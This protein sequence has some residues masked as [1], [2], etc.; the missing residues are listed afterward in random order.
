MARDT[1]IPSP[2]IAL[3]PYQRDA[4]D[5]LYAYW[6]REKG[7][8]LIVAPTGSGKSILIATFVR[9]AREN[10]PGTRFL[11]AT[12]VKE[13]IAQNFSA[14]LRAW[15]TAPAGIYSAGL[16]QRSI[17]Q[18]IIFCGIQ[19][20]HARAEIFGHV[21]LLLVDEAHLIPRNSDTMYG[22]FIAALRKINPAMKVVGFTATPYRL[23]SGRLDKGDTRIFDGIAFDIGIARLVDEGHLAPLVSKATETALDVSGVKKRGGEYIEAELQKAVDKE[24]VTEKAVAEIVRYGETRK[25]WLL[26]CAGVDHARH[27]A[28]ALVRLGINAAFVHGGMADR[29]RDRALSAFKAG[30]LRAVANANLLTTGFDHPTLDLIALL[31]PTLSTGLYVQMLGRGMRPAPGKENCIAEGQRVLTNT[32][33][34]PIERVTTAMKVWD[35]VE[36]VSH[37]GIILQGEQEVITY[38]GLTATPDHKVWTTKGWKALGKCAVERTPVRITGIEGK[39]VR[40][41]VGCDWHDNQKDAQGALAFGSR[42]FDLRRALFEGIY[43]LKEKHCRLPK[44]RQSEAGS[45]VACYAGHSS[46]AALHKSEGQK[47]PG[48]WGAWDRISLFFSNGNGGLDSGEFGTSPQYGIGSSEQRWSLRGWK[49]SLRN[50]KGSKEKHASRRKKAKVYDII[51]SGP[52]HR[53]T[54]EGL[55]V[56]N[57]VILDFARN[58]ARHGPVDMVTIKE[59]GEGGGVAPVKI[60]LDCN[61]ILHTAIRECPD[62]GYVFPFKTADDKIEASASK[63]AVMARDLIPTWTRCARWIFARHEKL[64]GLPTVRVEYQCGLQFHR[65]WLCPQHDGFARRKFE[66]WWLT[67]EGREPFPAT[68]EDVLSRQGELTCPSEIMVRKAG[69]Y[70]EIASRRFQRQEEAA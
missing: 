47:I 61:S 68:V 25:S 63:A 20:V 37:D 31:R 60:C 4:L 43:Q 67:H 70:F 1:A 12:H 62:C 36:F 11:I 48:L 53:F 58:I 18:P 5:G 66:R 8:P 28:E 51:N 19:S 29:E 49:S 56:S 35:G 22:R 21:D 59:P 30:Q 57:C 34:V 15:P 3:R 9:E 27:V 38:A 2:M 64:G 69:K 17:G 39:A 24:G 26:F 40:A 55:L 54:V 65:E 42:V 16:G 10:F 46:Q 7:N 6:E 52:R 33:L 41:S 13:L 44:M 14:M 23:D 32:G 50:F 45:E